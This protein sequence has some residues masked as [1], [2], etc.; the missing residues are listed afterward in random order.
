[1]TASMRRRRPLDCS[2]RLETEANI[3]DV[4]FRSALAAEVERPGTENPAFVGRFPERGDLGVPIRAQRGGLRV[5]AVDEAPG[6]VDGLRAEVDMLRS[7]PSH[8]R[9]EEIARNERDLRDSLRHLE[10]AGV[11]L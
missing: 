4:L 6:A 3:D 7:H 11:V 1:M 5:V 10:V 9:R 8:A 2:R